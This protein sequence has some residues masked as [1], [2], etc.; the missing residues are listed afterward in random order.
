MWLYYYVTSSLDSRHLKCSYN[1]YFIGISLKIIFKQN[2]N[3]ENENFQNAVK[4]RQTPSNAVERRQTPPTPSNAVDGAGRKCRLQLWGGTSFGSSKV[5]R[6]PV[7]FWNSVFPIIRDFSQASS[8][9]RL[10]L[11]FVLLSS[12]CRA[13]AELIF[14]FMSPRIIRRSWGG[15]LSMVWR[16]CS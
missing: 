10:P 14:A 3:V 7:R 8:I 12:V 4:R 11:S 6:F 15:V 2:K 5:H 1:R 13:C 9:N 16:N